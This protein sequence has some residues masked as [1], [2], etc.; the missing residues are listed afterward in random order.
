M[1]SKRHSNQPATRVHGFRSTTFFIVDD[2]ARGAGDVRPAYAAATYRA[3]EEKCD[4]FRSTIERH[5][6]GADVRSVRFA[7]GQNERHFIDY[8]RL[9]LLAKGPDD[10]FVIYFH[11]PHGKAVGNG[12]NY[13]W[14]VMPLTKP[15]YS[16]LTVHQELLLRSAR[17]KFCQRLRLH[18]AAQRQRCEY[19]HLAGRRHAKSFPRE[20]QAEGAYHRDHTGWKGIL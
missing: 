12:E 14:C 6:I 4:N 7:P 2:V 20:P 5:F 17:A 3:H 10:L 1:S 16:I 9:Q 13:Q 19:S 18:R 8:F 15:G 11:C